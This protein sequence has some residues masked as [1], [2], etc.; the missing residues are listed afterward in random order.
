M[1]KLIF[2]AAILATG[3]SG[4]SVPAA[5]DAAAPRGSYRDSCRSIRDRGDTLTAECR[6]NRGRYRQTAL[7]YRGCRGDIGN[8][9]GQLVCG[10]RP[11]GPGWGGGPGGPGGPGW[12]GG[13]GGPGGPGWGGGPGG[14]GGPGWGGGGRMPGGSWAQSCSNPSMRGST[15]SARCDN[16]RGDRRE[17]SIDMRSCRTGNL[18]NSYG[19][20]TCQ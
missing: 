9:N 15:F 14:P 2:A 8:D 1:K 5:A 12:G 11:G 18:A 7:R 3:L 20:L 10:G 4:A 17:S 13:G 6:D 16:G 19:R